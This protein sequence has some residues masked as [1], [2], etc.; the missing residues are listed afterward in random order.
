MGLDNAATH[1]ARDSYLR[2]CSK[3]G[4]ECSRGK[5]ADGSGELAGSSTEHL[6]LTS[7]PV[8]NIRSVGTDNAPHSV[9]AG[10]TAGPPMDGMV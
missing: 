9:D 4:I 2:G 1:T 7:A 8:H 10:F 6:C 5:D 3:K